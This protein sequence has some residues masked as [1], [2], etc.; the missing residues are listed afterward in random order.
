MVILRAP[1]ASPQHSHMQGKPIPQAILDAAL[2]ASAVE[3]E[4]LNSER[5]EARFGS[6]GI[7]VISDSGG[8]RLASLYSGSGG[9][10]VCRT[11]A[12]VRRQARSSD[13]I[14]AEQADIAAGRSIGARFRES[15]WSVAKRTLH[16]GAVPVSRLITEVGQRMRLAEDTSVAVHAYQLV[17]G[18][19]RQ[20]ID[21]ATIIEAHHPDYLTVDALPGLYRIT[22]A[23][24]ATIA[25]REFDELLLLMGLAKGPPRGS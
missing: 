21:Y 12:S 3:S 8:Q 15:G 2:S 17:L 1:E 6:Y 22:T 24:D 14:D 4:V 9:D 13:S 11:F 25:P 16:A 19:E 10:R 20:T 23:A 18:R 5:I 7:E